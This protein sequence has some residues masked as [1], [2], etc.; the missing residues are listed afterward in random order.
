MPACSVQPRK[1]LRKPG[2]Y[3][4][5]GVR[6]AQRGAGG[7]FG[8]PHHK[9]GPHQQQP[10]VTAINTR[11]RWGGFPR[12]SLGRPLHK[13]LLLN[14]LF[15][16][17]GWGNEGQGGGERSGRSRGHTA[18]LPAPGSPYSPNRTL[19]EPGSSGTPTP[20]SVTLVVTPAAVRLNMGSGTVYD[21]LSVGIE[22]AKERAKDRQKEM[23]PSIFRV[24]DEC[25]GRRGGRKIRVIAE[26]FSTPAT[27][28][29]T[30]NR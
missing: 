15:V 12:T 29:T 10:I 7:C 14:K 1:A 5:V 6:W 27:W 13:A 2:V 11:P 23:D 18:R 22:R 8:G 28:I 26:R 20:P 24:M 21:P 4:L 3:Q 30:A 25:H 16:T 19:Q 17:A 9:Q